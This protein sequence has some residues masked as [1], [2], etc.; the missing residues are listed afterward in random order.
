M[1]IYRAW[2]LERFRTLSGGSILAAIIALLMVL[3]AAPFV[4]E[5][6]WP[7]IPF[8]RN[9][10]VPTV[11]TAPAPAVISQQQVD[12]RIAEATKQLK[13]QLDQAKRETENLR[14]STARQ[15]AGQGQSDVPISV[16]KL[17]TSLQLHFEDNDI[18]EIGSRNVVWT[19][20][21]GWREGETLLSRPRPGWTIIVVFK[22][23]IAYKQVHYDDHGIHLN[24]VPEE[25]SSDP[26]Y[27]VLQ[28]NSIFLNGLLLDI[29]F[30]NEQSK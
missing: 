1:L 21:L 29:A 7:V 28:L 8:F 9:P 6:R 11:P 16:D 22:K 17:P 25:I 27:Y 13:A 20:M 2:L 4:Q 14:Q 18:K 24:P 5:G 3:T 26:H 23:P 30:T 15:I 10:T 19:K 12:E